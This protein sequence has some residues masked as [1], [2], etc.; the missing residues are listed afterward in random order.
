MI[1]GFFKILINFRILKNLK[2]NNNYFGRILLELKNKIRINANREDVFSALNDLDILQ[3]SIPGCEALE[4][5]EET[6]IKATVVAKIGPIK[7]KFRGTAVLSDL[8]PPERYTISGEG[9]GGAAGFAKGRASIKLLKEGDGTIVDYVVSAEV[10]GKLAQLGNRLIE[11]T[12]KRLAEQFFI[13]FENNIGQKVLPENQKAID[14]K[15]KKSPDKQSF[16]IPTMIWLL[17]GVIMIGG[18]IYLY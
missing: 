13:N 18:A 4:K 6:K 7:A 14:V 5:T 1:V 12:S 15:T 9:K 2:F 8:Q 11:G 10:G 3:K 16:P 17:I